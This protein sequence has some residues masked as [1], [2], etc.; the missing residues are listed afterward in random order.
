MY[1]MYRKPVNIAACAKKIIRSM[2]AGMILATGC[3]GFFCSSISFSIK[4]YS[5]SSLDVVIML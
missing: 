4:M 5:L 1:A 3:F 2:N